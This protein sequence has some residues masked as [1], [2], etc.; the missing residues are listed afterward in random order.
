MRRPSSPMAGHEAVA[1]V[2]GGG[3]A[4]G[5]VVDEAGHGY[6]WNDELLRPARVRVAE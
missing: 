6:M 1:T 5:T 3:G 4:A 2:R